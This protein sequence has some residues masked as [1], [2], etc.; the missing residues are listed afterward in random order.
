[1]ASPRLVCAGVTTFGLPSISAK[2]RFMFGNLLTACT[3]AY[4]SRCV[5]EI[6]P[7]RVRLRWLLMTVRLSII[8]L[9]GMARTLV[10]VGTSSEAFMFLTTAAA[11]PRS[12]ATSS[13]SPGGGPAGALAALAGSA[14]AAAGS[15]LRGGLGLAA[16][17]SAL[18]GSALAA[19]GAGLGSG[20]GAGLASA[21][22]AGFG[23]GG[24]VG[25]PLAPARTDDA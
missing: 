10:A 3:I 14:F 21:G 5:K 9:A 4:P 13:S 15:A 25:P 18:A 12:T 6:L 22:G 8:N 17:G 1:M 11:A 7:P 2:C 23:V 20:V 16:A 19:A 24:A